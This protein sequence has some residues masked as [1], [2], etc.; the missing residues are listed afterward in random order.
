MKSLWPAAAMLALTLSQASAATD[1]S[2]LSELAQ[3]STLAPTDL[4]AL[5]D[6]CDATQQAM[7]FCAWRDLILAERSLQRAKDRRIA[8][9]PSCKSALDAR[10]ARWLRARD[11]SCA[12]FAKL[13]FG[14]GSME[15][16]DRV[17]CATAQ[18]RELETRLKGS[19]VLSR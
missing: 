12:R 8:S 10:L 14:G 4:S 6:D 11:A 3:R 19:S 7:Y 9:C 5:L 13:D 2:V 15:P 1:P 16:T 17:L 18:T